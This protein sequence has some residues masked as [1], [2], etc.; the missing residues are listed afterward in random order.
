MSQKDH[1]KDHMLRHPT[2][3]SQWR[4]IEGKYK[5]FVEEARNI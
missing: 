5:E 3:V 1:K 4:K 2:D